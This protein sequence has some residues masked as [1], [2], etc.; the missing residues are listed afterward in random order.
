MN[1]D[2]GGKMNKKKFLPLADF[3]EAYCVTAACETA[4]RVTLSP[5][6][7]IEKKV[8]KEWMH[9]QYVNQNGYYC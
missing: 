4:V 7:Q 1:S 6:S 8:A 3:L 2:H 5:C 9:P